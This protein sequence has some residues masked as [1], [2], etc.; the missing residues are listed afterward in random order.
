[1]RNSRKV[2]IT[3]Y[4]TC[5]FIC[6]ANECDVNILQEKEL[7]DVIDLECCHTCRDPP[8]EAA[9]YNLEAKGKMM[10]IFRADVNVELT[11]ELED[12]RQRKKQQERKQERSAVEL[13]IDF[14]REYYALV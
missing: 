2:S 4:I 12:K 9:M 1:M 5:S 3:H 11:V 8:F 7:L 14:T 6:Y 13:P 10:E